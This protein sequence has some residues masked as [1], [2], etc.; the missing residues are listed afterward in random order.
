[1]AAFTSDFDISVGLYKPDQTAEQGQRT[2]QTEVLGISDAQLA[3]TAYRLERL[4]IINA[5]GIAAV[6]GFSRLLMLLQYAVGASP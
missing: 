4:P 1:M 5:R 2:I 6:M 3:A